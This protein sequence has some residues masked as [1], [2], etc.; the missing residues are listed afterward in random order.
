MVSKKRCNRK[1]KSTQINQTKPF[2]M[3][4][5]KSFFENLNFNEPGDRVEDG[6]EEGKVAPGVG[7]QLHLDL[8]LKIAGYCS[9][10]LGPGLVQGT[11]SSLG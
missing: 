9:L 2:K 4:C 10:E 8:V 1:A 3:C 6:A 7:L 11:Q 5:T